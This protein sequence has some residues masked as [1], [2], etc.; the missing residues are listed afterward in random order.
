MNP[1]RFAPRSVGV[2]PWPGMTVSCGQVRRC[3]TS[4][5]SVRL[6]MAFCLTGASEERCGGCWRSLATRKDLVGEGTDA[7]GVSC[8]ELMKRPRA[9]LG[10]EDP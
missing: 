5:S 9:A 1:T 4:P 8:S 2:S 3:R 7:P 6:R 10:I